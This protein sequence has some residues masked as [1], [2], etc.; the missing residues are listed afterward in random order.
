[1][2]FS[3]PILAPTAVSHALD[4]LTTAQ[5][6]M[7][8]PSFTTWDDFLQNSDTSNCPIDSCALFNNDCVTAFSGGSEI[9]ISGTSPW[10]VTMDLSGSTPYS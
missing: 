7:I 3:A 1:M 9:S 4:G 5:A 8:N 10:G 6:I 2:T